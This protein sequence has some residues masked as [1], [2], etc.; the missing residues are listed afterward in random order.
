MKLE[1]INVYFENFNKHIYEVDSLEFWFA[2]D[3]QVLLGYAKWENF[4]NV[5]EKAKEACR[6]SGARLR[7]ILLIRSGR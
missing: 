1:L 7:I 5:I 4:L 6:N 3:L 2:R